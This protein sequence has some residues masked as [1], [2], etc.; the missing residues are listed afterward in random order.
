[1]SLWSHWWTRVYSMP[2]EKITHH[3]VE[4]KQLKEE[5]EQLR[6]EYE[7]LKKKRN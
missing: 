6:K 2:K 3:Y 7:Q 1:M 5:N 4:N